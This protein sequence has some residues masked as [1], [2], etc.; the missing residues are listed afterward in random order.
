[1]ALTSQDCVLIKKGSQET[2]THRA[3]TPRG[4]REETAVY[5]PRREASGGPALPTR[6]SETP[7]SRAGD[8]VFLWLKPGRGTCVAA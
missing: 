6:G 1:M 2:G 4:H 8:D 3:T 5:M 7:A